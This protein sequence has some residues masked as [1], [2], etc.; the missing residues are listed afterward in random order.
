MPRRGPLLEL[1]RE[2]HAALVLARDCKRADDAEALHARI[3]A[4]HRDILA[5]H[6]VREEALLTTHA[7]AIAA[8]VRT[9]VLDDHAWLRGWI[10]A[11]AR[12]L[13]A[14]REYG[15]RIGA[16]VRFEEQ[17]LWP[18]LQPLVDEAPGPG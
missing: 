10:K 3:L 6:F 16:H 18:I 11:G 5:A 4:H 13:A 2:H 14:I 12:D 7:G 1:S 15:V 17:V 9:L 8:D